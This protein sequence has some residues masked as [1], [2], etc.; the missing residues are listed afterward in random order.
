[1]D[2]VKYI[3]TDVHKEAISIARAAFGSP[4]NLVGKNLDCGGPQM[5]CDNPK[6]CWLRASLATRWMAILVAKAAMTRKRKKDPQVQMSVYCCPHCNRWHLTRCKR[7][8]AGIPKELRV[9]DG[10][11]VAVLSHTAHA[12]KP[13]TVLQ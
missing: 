6:R 1:M 12:G 7:N 11:G 10:S 5:R 8:A 4:A 2:S 13:K 9:W 3:G